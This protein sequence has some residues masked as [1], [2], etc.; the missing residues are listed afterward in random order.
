MTKSNNNNKNP[1]SNVLI[2]QLI[3]SCQYKCDFKKNKNIPVLEVVNEGEVGA[4]GK[5]FGG[6]EG[7]S[8]S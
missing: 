1:K 3:H 6:A 5:R 4:K 7:H 2:L 8:A